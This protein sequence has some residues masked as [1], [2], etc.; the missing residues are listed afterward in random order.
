VRRRELLLSSLCLPWLAPSAR[1]Q[2]QAGVAKLAILSPDPPSTAD[3][4]SGSLLSIFLRAMQEQGYVEGRNIQIEF[5]FAENR[6]DRLP[7]LAAE[8]VAWG[9]TVLYTYTSGGARAAANATK[10]VPIVVGPSAEAILLALAGNLAHPKGNVTGLSLEGLGQTEKCL[11]IL[12]ELAPD[13]SR[14]GLVVNPDNPA[15]AEYPDILNSAAGRLGITLR[16]V[17]IRG[18]AD[19]DRMLA[20]PDNEKLAGL[21][22]AGDSTF[23]P[24]GPVGRGIIK[25]AREN[26]LPSASTTIGFAEHGGLVA[27][28]ADQG[29]LRRRAADY[30]HRIIQGARPGDLPIERPSKFQLSI[31]LST[32]KALGLAI[33]QSILARADEVIE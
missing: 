28:G 29:Y 24:S 2:S 13:A 26:H 14:I 30:V 15:W 31:N 33:P 4:T 17:A 23:D 10:S 19:I 25:S 8:L 18:A 6:L 16:R 9:P 32:A 20:G 22:M 1:A 3:L 7:A 11:E 12:K 5:R 27:F 21:L